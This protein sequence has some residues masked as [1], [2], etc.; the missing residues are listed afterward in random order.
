MASRLAVHAFEVLHSHGNFELLRPWLTPQVLRALNERRRLCR[1]RLSDTRPRIRL[2]STR[3]CSPAPDVMEVAV[4]VAVGD[5]NHAA[6]A[7][8]E[9]HRGKWRMSALELV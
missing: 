2:V 6:A 5:R 8:M 4:V 7:R 1:N 9:F 3:S